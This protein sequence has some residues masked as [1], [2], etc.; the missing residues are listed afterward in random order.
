MRRGTSRDEQGS[1]LVEFVWLGM[2]LLVPLVYV[3]IAV[4]DVQRGAFGVAAASRAAGRAYALADTDA[5][6][7]RQARAAALI[8]LADQGLDGHPFD[9]AITCQP[10]PPP[11]HARGKT[12]VVQIGS[13]V[14][15]PLSPPALG[16]DAPTFAVSAEHRV[17][18]GRYRDLSP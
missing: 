12:I 7:A 1:A 8:A 17:P 4:F 18:I 15:L 6:G 3:L 13:R 9:L 16:G 11:C 5:E 2:L 14:T 10:G